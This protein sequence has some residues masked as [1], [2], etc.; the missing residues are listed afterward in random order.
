MTNN[1]KGARGRGVFGFSITLSFVFFSTSTSTRTCGFHRCPT[2]TGGRK[3]GDVEGKTCKIS[4]LI[5]RPN[6]ILLYC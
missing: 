2:R 1:L 6:C 5:P 3:E 4:T